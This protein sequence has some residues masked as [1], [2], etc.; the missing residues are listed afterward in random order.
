MTR[1]LWIILLVVML[2]F[3]V[4]YFGLPFVF[5]YRVDLR[6]PRKYTGTKP[7]S[8][9]SLG[10]IE[11]LDPASGKSLDQL[12]LR[13]YN[14]IYAAIGVERDQLSA[15]VLRHGPQGTSR[16]GDVLAPEFPVLSKV[17]WTFVDPVD[18]TS[19]DAENLMDECS[20]AAQKTR[21]VAV[22]RELGAIREFAAKALAR[23]ATLRFGHA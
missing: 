3:F 23:S 22:T 4:C 1:S 7:M 11:M 20:R 5:G 12:D 18:L 17:A 14:E 8:A 9:R 15:W 6:Q 19:D 16:T 21:N 2:G 10:V 13:H